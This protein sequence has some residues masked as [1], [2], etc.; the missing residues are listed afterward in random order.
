MMLDAAV[1]TIV[2]ETIISPPGCF[3]LFHSPAKAMT[4]ALA[5]GDGVQHFAL[6]VPFIKAGSRDDAPALGKALLEGRFFMQC[7]RAGVIELIA[8]RFLLRPMRYQPQRNSRTSRRSH[9]RE[10]TITGTR[11]FGLYDS[12]GSNGSATSASKATANSLAVAFCEYR[13]HMMTV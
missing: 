12:C 11:A 10:C 9:L 8:N 6:S 2:Q 7:F 4:G 13:L 1:V 5:W 3:H